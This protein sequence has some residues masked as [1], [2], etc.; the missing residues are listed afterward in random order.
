MLQ[1]AI[2]TP[3]HDAIGCRIGALGDVNAYGA[4]GRA[5]YLSNR[6]PGIPQAASTGGKHYAV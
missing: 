5:P 6:A 1:A 4:R 3:M 2:R